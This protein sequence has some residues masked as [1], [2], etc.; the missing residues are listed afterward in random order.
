V[1]AENLTHYHL[2]FKEKAPQTEFRQNIDSYNLDD[3]LSKHIRKVLAITGGK[4]DGPDGAAV[5]L[6]VNRNTL[7]ARMNKLG[8]EYGRRFK[9]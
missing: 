2:Q 5:L 8:I 9:K 6:N 7:R 4:V 3:V 1:V